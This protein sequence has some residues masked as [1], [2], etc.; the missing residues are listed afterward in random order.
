MSGVLP[1]FENLAKARW[2][3][4][5]LSDHNR[6]L[7]RALDLDLRNIVNAEQ[8]LHALADFTS[9]M[10]DRYAVRIARMLTGI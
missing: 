6:Q 9:G 8:A 7:V 2:D 10:T 3:Q 4:E 5:N 1:L